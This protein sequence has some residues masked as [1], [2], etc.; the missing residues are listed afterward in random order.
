MIERFE[1]GSTLLS[2]LG[3]RK[4]LAIDIGN[5]HN[6]EAIIQGTIGLRTINNSE[7]SIPDTV[8]KR[9]YSITGP[10]N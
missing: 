9:K 8:P 3:A 5:N 4:L 6:R 1:I 10:I 7:T 2:K